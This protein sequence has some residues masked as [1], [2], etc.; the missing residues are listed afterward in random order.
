MKKERVVVNLH[1]KQPYSVEVEVADRNDRKDLL[2]KARAEFINQISQEG[3]FPAFSYSV[4]D[5]NSLTFDNA[6]VGKVVVDKKNNEEALITG[7]NPKSI[8]VVT[9]EGKMLRGGPSCF[10]VVDEKN[11]DVTKIMR[12]RHDFDKQSNYWD[13]GNTGYL[14]ANKEIHSVVIGKSRGK[15]T[16]AYKING[17]GV[18]YKLQDQHLRFLVDTKEEA[19]VLASK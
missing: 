1:F 8:D 7:I 10:E 5:A 13:E 4:S 18:H 11:Y 9:Q 6:Y 19:E 12:Q 3:K 2:E 15:T 16:K 17:N 14:V